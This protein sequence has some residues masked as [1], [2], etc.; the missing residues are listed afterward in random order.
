[1]CVCVCVCACASCRFT[2][3]RPTTTYYHLHIL[4]RLRLHVC[5]FLFTRWWRLVH[6]AAYVA[7]SSARTFVHH[8][9]HALN[10]NSFGR[11]T[12]HGVPIRLQLKRGCNC[13]LAPSFSNKFR[14]FSILLL[15]SV[16]ARSAQSVLSV[17]QF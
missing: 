1:M 9:P 10:S 16:F 11:N 15:W 2:R 6:Q 8:R 17:H 3:S 14:V 12:G 7:L 13:A 4:P 5:M